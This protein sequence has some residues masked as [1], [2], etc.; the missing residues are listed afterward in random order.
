VWSLSEVEV[1]SLSEVEVWSLS[2]VEV[3]SLSEVEVWISCLIWTYPSPDG[4]SQIN[5][6]RIDAVNHDLGI[7]L[8]ILESQFSR[9]LKH[10]V[11]I[12]FQDY[13]GQQYI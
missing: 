7:K 2:E 10:R 1:W 3:W 11:V 12:S 8:I 13:L 5:K 9:Y 4:L 6:K